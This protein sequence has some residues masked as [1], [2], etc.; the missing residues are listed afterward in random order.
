M[1][2]MINVT[3]RILRDEERSMSGSGG[4]GGCCLKF[5]LASVNTISVDLEQLSVRLL[6]L[7]HFSIFSI[8]AFLVAMLLAGMIK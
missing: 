4:G 1:M 5:R 2:M 8:S 7:D 3:P 6:R